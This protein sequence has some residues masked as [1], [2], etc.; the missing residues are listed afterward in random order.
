MADQDRDIDVDETCARLRDVLL[1]TRGLGR[2]ELLTA[3]GRAFAGSALLATLP[4]WHRGRKR[5]SRR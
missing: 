4:A 1:E 5:P 3:L 2:R